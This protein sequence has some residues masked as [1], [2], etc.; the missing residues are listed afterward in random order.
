MAQ[1]EPRGGGC[2]RSCLSTCGEAER[3]TRTAAEGVGVGLQG[4]GG[5]YHGCC[6]SAVGAV[7]RLD[8]GDISKGLASLG[9][10]SHQLWME[11]L[12]PFPHALQGAERAGKAPSM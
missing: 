4:Q 6:L 8:V 1:S 7:A 5:T 10:V 11:H 9:A 12:P 2:L 3:D